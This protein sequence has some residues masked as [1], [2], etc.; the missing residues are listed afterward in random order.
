MIVG[1]LTV[2]PK[3][4]GAIAM[5]VRGVKIILFLQTELK[6]KTR[7]LHATH[8]HNT[9]TRYT[10]INCLRPKRMKENT[11]QSFIISLRFSSLQT[12]LK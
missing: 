10:Q 6:K 11:C 5:V 3:L 1:V 2:I 4:G 8:R 9:L 12:D 7:V